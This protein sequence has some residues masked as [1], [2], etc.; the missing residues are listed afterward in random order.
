MTWPNDKQ[1]PGDADGR[2]TSEDE[3]RGAAAFKAE[4]A[5][6]TDRRADYAKEFGTEWRS[7]T[8]GGE[9]VVSRLSW[10]TLPS[11]L[12]NLSIIKTKNLEESR[13]SLNLL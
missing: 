2:R 11:S 3:T 7:A 8:E 10:T 9:G 12:G 5:Y 1:D 6:S 13:C 4:E